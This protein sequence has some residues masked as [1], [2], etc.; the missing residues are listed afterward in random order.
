M[1]SRRLAVGLLAWTLGACG[2]TDQTGDAVVPDETQGPPSAPTGQPSETGSATGKATTNPVGATA[3]P[4]GTN[5]TAGAGAPAPGSTQQPTGPSDDASAGNADWTPEAPPPAQSAPDQASV[6]EPG[7]VPGSQPARGRA[8]PMPARSA[9]NEGDRYDGVGTNPFVVTAHDPF[10]TFA[11]D[12]DSA[13]YDLF[14]RDVNLGIVPRPTSVRLEEYIN[15]FSYDYPA[16]D[17]EGAAPFEISLSAASDA[18]GRDTTVLRVGI[19][20]KPRAAFAKKPTNLV[21]LIDTSGSMRSNE[22]LPLVQEMLTL[23]LDFLDPEDTV[24]IVTYAGATRVALEPT[25]VA[26]KAQIAEVINS[27]AAGGSTAGASGI[28]LAYEQAQAGFIDG[29]INHVVL[30][31]DGDFNVGASS[32]DALVTLIEDKRT[33]G[34]TLTALG[35][36]IGNLNDSMME[37]VS[38]AGNGI[39]SVI[40]SSVHAERYV[41][42]RMLSSLEHIAKDVKIQ[43][44]FNPDHVQA[45]RLLG[46]E[47]RAIADDLFRDDSVD[48]GEVGAGH[49]VTALY[50]LVLTNQELP[51]VA[52]APA[53]DDGEP[54]EG[55]REIDPSDLVLLKVRY[56]S[57]EASESDPAA[58][59][60]ATLSPDNV[61]EGLPAADDDLAW[62]VAVAGLAEILK[63]S[64]YGDPAALPTI[65]GI[66]RPQASRDADRTEFVELY[67]KLAPMLNPGM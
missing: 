34:V 31:T 56:K 67:D 24:S 53:T 21:F 6:M 7:A 65:E 55:E 50:E 13:S 44:E 54:V 3:N 35:F 42:E 47:N 27:F 58:E 18:L 1:I 26:D 29:G 59:I 32:D 30:C 20:G 15:N 48:A 57:P 40:S 19:Q 49:T 16:P 4:M 39:Y 11:A 52:D 23:T 66:I 63:K 62:A 43:V 46:Y 2:G 64:P 5:A 22:K 61:H 37:K 10:S 33:T 45:Y 8:Q 38:N 25:A 12:V 17:R 9:S 36:G 51:E 28:K 60:Q 14:R 41:S